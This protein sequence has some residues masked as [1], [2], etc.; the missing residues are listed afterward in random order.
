[1]QAAPPA[2]SPSARGAAGADPREAPPGHLG[3]DPRRHRRRLLALA[4]GVLLVL[5]LL[6]GAAAGAVPVPVFPLQRLDGTQAVILLQIRLPRVVLA[7]LT[8]AALSTAGAALQALFRNPLA[9]P[10]VL[11]VSSGAA[12]AATL[13]IAFLPALPAAAGWGLAWWSL[14]AAA[15]AG[16][17]ATLGAVLLLGRL[18]GRPGPATLLLAGVALSTLLSAG[19]SLVATLQP[20][21]LGPIT[22]WLLGGFSGAGWR[23]VT[24]A[25][26][27]VLLGL[28][29]LLARHREL[30][31]LLL[32]EERAGYLGVDVPRQ[33]LALL[34]ATSLLTAGAVAL[35]G[36][37][38]FVGLLVPHLYRLLS[39]ASHR[40]LLPLSAAGGAAVMVGADL[41]AR[42][43]MAP[44]ELPV[45][46][47][48]ALLGAPFF[49]LILLRVEG[50]RAR[51]P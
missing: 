25:A 3:P 2:R 15:F 13:V 7:A 30:D 18:L 5:A 46:V 43:L 35:S 50:G 49:L 32:G 21:R 23:S 29:L 47:V 39:G 51:W 12:L 8:G 26:P 17:A 27:P 1:M 14:P 45:G 38:G 48:T 6:A 11:G 22:F 40:W 4:T 24:L 16:A 36:M 31:A 28:G 34:V 10:Y 9:D 37:I 42:T 44:G 41:L 33:L 20:S 19:V